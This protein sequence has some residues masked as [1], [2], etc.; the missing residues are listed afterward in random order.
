MARLRDYDWSIL[1][2]GP[3]WRIYCKRSPSEST[4]FFELNLEGISD[5]SDPRLIYFAA[6]FSAPSFIQKGGTTDIDLIYEGGVSY[7]KGLEEDLKSKVFNDQLF[8]N[9]VRSTIVFERTKRYSE[10]DL[11]QGKR[12]ALK[13]LYRL[14]FILYAEARGLMPL[15]NENYRAI[16]LENMRQRL[17]ALEKVP[18]GKEAWQSMQALFHTIHQGDSSAQMPEY[19]GDL[20]AEEEIDRLQ[21]PNLHLVSALKDLML[22]AGGG[23]DYLNLGVRQLGSIYE[24]LLEYSVNQAETDLMVYKD[25]SSS[26]DGLSILDASFASD[27]QAK[28]KSFIHAGEIYLTVGGLARKGTGSYYTP[29]EIVCYLVKEGLKPHF[30]HREALSREDMETLRAIKGH[31]PKLEQKTIEDLLGLEVVDPAMGSGHFLVAAANEITSWAISLLQE[32]PDAPLIVQ[33]EEDRK[34][35]LEEQAKRGIVLDSEQLTDAAILKRMYE[36]L[37]LWRGHQFHGR[38]AGQ[39]LLVAGVLH[40]RLTPHLPEP[41]HALR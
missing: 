39:A 23:I 8:L 4:S 7:A 18:S 21:I 2:N 32:N 9:L 31:D 38:G 36:A 13:L 33:V 27:L 12:R 35:I 22:S 3:V 37:R 30:Q 1:S 16:S 10:T 24:A 34:Q 26:K 25:S 19:D 11:E 15:Q 28:P 29:D 41:P 5:A 14:L 40:H 6:I 17:N 20:F